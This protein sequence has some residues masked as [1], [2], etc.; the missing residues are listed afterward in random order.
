MSCALNIRSSI[1]QCTMII[2]QCSMILG[3]WHPKPPPLN[4]IP[5]TQSPNAPAPDPAQRM[6]A[7]PG[8]VLPSVTSSTCRT[9]HLTHGPHPWTRTTVFLRLFFHRSIFPFPCS[10]GPSGRAHS[11]GTS[12][13]GRVAGKQRTA[14][15]LWP[16]TRHQFPVPIAGTNS[17]YRFLDRRVPRRSTGNMQSRSR[18]CIRER[19]TMVWGKL[20]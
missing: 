4:P 11:V 19:T 1:D 17:R 5:S 13:S 7:E 16:M 3:Q 8:A 12:G 9:R 20:E 18:E 6:L 10:A 14:G 15:G 2:D